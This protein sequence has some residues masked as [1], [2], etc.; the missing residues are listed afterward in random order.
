MK[1]K[2][3]WL[4]RISSWILDALPK[5]ESAAN[6]TK[7]TVSRSLNQKNTI[8]NKNYHDI[9]NDKTKTE[10]IEIS[11]EDIT[12]KAWDKFIEKWEEC[13]YSTKW[14]APKSELSGLLS[15]LGKEFKE[16]LAEALYRVATK[17]EAILSLGKIIERGRVWAGDNITAIRSYAYISI[18]VVKQ[19]GYMDGSEENALKRID[20]SSG[21]KDT[22]EEVGKLDEASLDLTM[23]SEITEDVK[24]ECIE[25]EDNA[26]NTPL[27]NLEIQIRT[28][29]CLYRS[30]YD[31]VRDLGGL[32]EEDY[33]QLKNFGAKALE[34]LRRGLSLIGVKIPVQDKRITKK[35][36]RGRTTAEAIQQ[37]RRDKG[38]EC[39]DAVSDYGELDE[40]IKRIQE[41]VASGNTTYD[42]AFKKICTKLETEQ[43]ESL[44]LHALVH[45]DGIINYLS[46]EQTGQSDNNNGL[47]GAIKKNALLK[48]IALSSNK[49]GIENWIKG[50]NR[51]NTTQAVRDF[52]LL[53]EKSK[54]ETYAN[55]AR[56]Q[57]PELSR[58]R[59][60]QAIARICKIL[61]I[62][63]EALTQKEGVLQKNAQ[64]EEIRKE[65]NLWIEKLGRLPIEN[66]DASLVEDSE[67]KRKAATMTPK[68]RIEIINSAGLHTPSK[69][70]DYHY[71][72]IRYGMGVVGNGYWLDFQ[73][74]KE[75]LFRHARVL[76]DKDLMP[77]QTSLP[78]SVR[79][80]VTRFGG[81]KRVADRIGLRYQGQLV[82]EDGGRRFWTDENLLDLLNKTNEHHEQ[83]TELMPSTGQIFEYVQ[84]TKDPKY[85]GKKAPSAIAALTQQGKLHWSEVATRFGK[86]FLIGESQRAV[87]LPF[88]KAF[89]RDLGEHLDSLSPAEI[90]VLFQ[91]QGI[92]RKDN[93]KFSRTFDVLVDAIQSG[94][95][96]KE[97][98]A[99]WANNN[100]VGSI[101][102]L[103]DLGSEI[104][105]SRSIEERESKYLTAKSKQIAEETIDRDEIVLVGKDDL[106]N[107]D[108]DRT[109]KALDKAADVIESTSTDEDKVEF[110]KA[111][112]TAKLWDACFSNEETIVHKIKELSPPL[113][114]YSAEVRDAF[115]EEYTE[116]KK[117]AIPESYK[118]KDLRGRY[119][120]PKLMQ[121][122]VAYR[123]KR[124]KRLLNLSGTG[125]GKT[126]SAIYAAQVCNSKRIMISCPNGVLNSWERAFVSAY[127]E[128]Q[129]HIKEDNWSI[130]NL[131]AR[132]H[133]Y[134]VN[135]ER[136]QEMYA[137]RI[138]AHCVGYAPDMIVI[139]EIHQSKRRT[140]DKTSQR[141]KLMNEYIKISINMD[142]NLRILGMS[143]TPVINNLYEGRSLLELVK[144]R[145]IDDVG[146]KIDL[147]SCMNLYQHFVRDGIRMNPGSLSRT[148]IILEDVNATEMLP[149]IIAA[150][151]TGTYH[152]V[153]QILVSSKISTLNRCLEKGRKTVVF[154]SYIKGTLKP[155]AKWLEQNQFTYSVY[156]GDDKEATDEG[157]TDAIDEFIRG[158]TEVLIASIKCVGTG[159]DGL[160]AVCDRAVFFQLPWTSTEFEQAIGRL[161]R[162]GTEFESVKVYLPVTDVHL[163]NGDRW[164]W[165]RSKLDRI[166]SKRDIAKAA[167]DG[168]VPD[169]ASM[170]SP[171]EATKYWIGWLK[172]LDE[173]Q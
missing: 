90:Y 154:I 50:V 133:V 6:E 75:F 73:N 113:D 99:E 141:R 118:F 168:E 72:Y 68:E 110:L 164:S 7:Q 131:D 145:R 27:K 138:L 162:D 39:V 156:T 158:N 94:V 15:A 71:N 166:R 129:L 167:V 84:E 120:E 24:G 36:L 122:L 77:K 31:V 125:T 142:P 135:H 5:E 159:V 47:I 74:L 96:S 37:S 48:I 140:E 20:E 143:A 70:Y 42:N 52:G 53:I 149:K 12:G 63:L 163:P 51:L 88:I 103:V 171:A 25:T 16:D 128:A 11:R 153:E 91:S 2:R 54:G 45:T 97:E 64:A 150:T 14:F 66:D 117:L 62:D 85:Q 126:L 41:D 92:S 60:R 30:G 89:V 43:K 107:L 65:I 105:S 4:D 9:N 19:V 170:I 44:V 161:D 40:E 136:F 112:A 67:A 13:G 115:L 102:E 165:C 76:G 86:K 147:N 8:D 61:E 32:D 18:L 134:I 80:V 28:L 57:I 106:P 49:E 100:E 26:F 22:G 173:K 123:L 83:D 101:E 3:S 104:K 33:L 127:P 59:I 109:L 46:S 69:E 130:P 111:K 144:Q 121:R 35:E 157:Y 21:I 34:D 132:T 155:I 152:D 151:K 82:G 137:D 139:D 116:S 146:E 55:L 160:Q 87:T 38:T 78:D 148:E 29:N 1:R 98:I 95:V 56:K 119:R 108:P 17:K 172:R 124:D 58:E 79:G 169:A 10:R 93:E 23:S 81:Q 114:A